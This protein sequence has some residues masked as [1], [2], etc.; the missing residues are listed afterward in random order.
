MQKALA[1]F[2]VDVLE[3][4]FEA[5]D[6]IRDE[7]NIE[8]L[9]HK[10]AEHL[11]DGFLLDCP[12]RTEKFVSLHEKIILKVNNPYD[13][14]ILDEEEKEICAVIYG[15]LNN[16]KKFAEVL[17]TEREQIKKKIQNSANHALQ[18]ALFEAS[19]GEAHES[20]SE[21]I[22][23]AK[24]VKKIYEE[25]EQCQKEIDELFETKK[26]DNINSF[27]RELNVNFR[28]RLDGRRYY[29]Q[30]IGYEPA[31]YDKENKVL[32][33]EGERRILALAYFLQEIS[34]V[35]EEKVVVV[36]NPISSLDISRKSVVA[37][38][39][40]ELMENPDTQVLVLSHDISFAE[41]IDSLS[42]N[43]IN[44]KMTEICKN[45]EEP[46]KPLNLRDYLITD[47]EVY[48]KIIKE[49]EEAND[50]NLKILALM[51]MRP[52]TSIKIGMKNDDPR[53]V[54]IEGRATHLAHSIYSRS[55]RVTYKPSKYGKAKMRTYCKRVAQYTKIHIDEKKMIPEDWDFAGIDFYNAWDIYKSF[56]TET[57]D[58]LRKKAIV[59]RSVLETT[60]FA[61][62]EKKKFNPER[63][64]QEYSKAIKGAIGE[65]RD[66]CKE[67]NRLYDLSKK[68]HH[69]TEGKSTL[70][71]SSLNP[72]E[73]RYFDEIITKIHFWLMSH[74]EEW[75]TNLS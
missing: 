12:E 49:G 61:L 36:D 68:Y 4:M 31:E 35:K 52:Y 67:L 37:F 5:L 46:F 16:Y 45:D 73:M 44:L 65:K 48:Y 59:L 28:V 22:V 9:L 71:I 63:I 74:T 32:C 8:R 26:I 1:F 6:R 3:E 60:L 51:A 34:M 18:V 14:V 23:M 13:A 19:Y 55:S 72:D 21:I 29:V 69:G 15:I 2:D 11:L 25:I 54:D 7:N 70:G 75:N 33:S 47:E 50:I 38:K 10:K 66:M 43:S 58:D 17:E 40:V 62:V 24:S 42:N 64:G 20:I 30:I 53:Y 56:S 39:L 27:L 57:I 41:K